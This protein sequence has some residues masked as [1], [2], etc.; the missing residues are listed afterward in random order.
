MRQRIRQ[1]GNK[2][3]IDISPRSGRWHKAWGVSP[4][5]GHSD[6]EPAERATA[7]SPRFAGFTFGRVDP[8]AYAPGFML[9]PA[10]RAYSIREACGRIDGGIGSRKRE[11]VGV[12]S[13]SG[14]R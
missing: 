8:G 2:F 9:P 3:N 1:R 12:P 7:L 14:P 5:S 11:R 6:T 4:R 13:V 10:S